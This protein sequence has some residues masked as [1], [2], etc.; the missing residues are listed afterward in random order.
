MAVRVVWEEDVQT[1]EQLALG[2]HMWIGAAGLTAA[3]GC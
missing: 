2:S 3:Y 1:W